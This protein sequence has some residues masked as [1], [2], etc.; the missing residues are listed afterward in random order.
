MNMLGCT[1]LELWYYT[2]RVLFLSML[3][4]SFDA[5]VGLVASGPWKLLQTTTGTI[6][7]PLYY[8]A[9]IILRLQLRTGAPSGSQGCK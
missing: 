6:L 5:G 3:F 9:C 8:T 4:L 1:S 2:T 7:W